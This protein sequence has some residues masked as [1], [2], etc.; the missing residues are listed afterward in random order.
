VD[1][2]ARQIDIPIS[3]N[4]HQAAG[5]GVVHSLDGLRA[6]AIGAVLG[7]HFG[8]PGCRMGGLGVDLFFVISGFLITTLLLQEHENFGDISLKNFWVRRALRLM[9]L[10]WLYAAAMT[11]WMLYDWQQLT[12]QTA[13]GW[14]PS[15]YIASI[16]FYCVNYAP[17]QGIWDHQL[18]FVGPLWSLA[19]EEQFYFT[20]PILL[21]LAMR[22]RRAWLLPLT[23]LLLMLI[24][25]SFV[26]ETTAFLFRLDTRGVSIVIGCLGAVLFYEHRQAAVLERLAS[27]R[28]R[29][30][31]IA[32]VAAI[33]LLCTVLNSW[34][35]WSQLDVHR[36]FDVI[37]GM[38]FVLLIGMLWYGPRDQLD[39]SL[40]WRP[41]AYLGTISY[42]VYILHGI[43]Q[44]LVWQVW[45]P[46]S[47]LPL[48]GAIRY[49]IRLSIALAL[50]F[51]AAALSY[52]LYEKRFLKLKRRFQGRPTALTTPHTRLALEA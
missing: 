24:R 7:A 5:R 40:S 13:S 43:C 20:W 50:T 12:P 46:D 18:H 28:I 45:L 51:G 27:A 23:L 19:I 32:V 8:V 16:W 17:I 39:K 41:I 4:L 49:P 35:G 31:A 15:E 52:E 44:W 30:V 29:C 1:T 26:T 37:L 14:T 34:L 2:V 48:P 22:T 11:I 42:G 47:L 3:T 38:S 10:Y 33:V 36:Y 6:V 21:S 9:P 25:R